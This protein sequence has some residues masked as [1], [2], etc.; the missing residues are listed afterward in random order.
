M[1]TDFNL[2]RVGKR[3]PYKVSDHFFEKLEENVFQQVQSCSSECAHSSDS[4]CQQT[5]YKLPMCLKW[6][7]SVAAV[8]VCLLGGSWW[9]TTQRQ[10]ISVEVEQA[11]AAL[12]IED[13]D[14]MLSV[15]QEDLFLNE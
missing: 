2:D 4:L 12:S 11:F 1:K 13:Q 9:L 5:K 6:G 8:V 14:Y 3:M 15:Y 10:S 7:A